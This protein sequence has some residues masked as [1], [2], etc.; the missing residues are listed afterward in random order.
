MKV[1]YILL[2]LLVNVFAEIEKGEY[3][4]TDSDHGWFRKGFYERVDKDGVMWE[5]MYPD[6]RKKK[7]HY[8]Y[9]LSYFKIAGRDFVNITMS[10]YLGI[11]AEVFLGSTTITGMITKTKVGF[12]LTLEGGK[13]IH[14]KRW[15]HHIV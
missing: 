1:L 12:F 5:D 8:A 14:F 11:D 9:S 2:F 13:T 6:H 7:K 10:T 3:V 15:K 4:I